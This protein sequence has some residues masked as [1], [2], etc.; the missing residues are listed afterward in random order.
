[1]PQVIRE[2]LDVAGLTPEDLDLLV[3][4][5]ANL[6]IN[7]AA[8]AALGLPEEKVVHNID[9]YGNTT[10]GSIPIALSEAI[11]DGRVS[12]GNLVCMAAFGAGFTWA[13]ALMRW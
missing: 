9:R 4:H 6:R 2:V 1:M 5:Q 3:P 8:A 7:Q 10:A 12:D 13:A 11:D